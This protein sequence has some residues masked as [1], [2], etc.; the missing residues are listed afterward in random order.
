L[1]LSQ[2]LLSQNPK[3]LYNR[4]AAGWVYIEI[5]KTQCQTLAQVSHSLEMIMDLA[6]ESSEDIFWEQIR[7]QI[8][9][10]LF[11][12][13]ENTPN[14][15]WGIFLSLYEAFPKHASQANSILLKSILKHQAE[16]KT[17]ALVSTISDVANLL[18]SDFEPETLD[19]GKS[20]PS[21][22]ERLFIA[23]AKNWCIIMDANKDFQDRERIS[24]FIQRLDRFSD[25]YPQMVYLIYYRAVLR[26]KLEIYEEARILFIPFVRKKQ[27][28]FWVWEV[29]SQTFPNDIDTQIACLSK[30]LLCKTS[31][32]FLVKVRQR[33]AELL[34]LKKD[35]NSAYTEILAIVTI[36]KQNNW[37][38]STQIIDW[39]KM[40]I[41]HNAMAYTNNNILY[42]T[43]SIIAENIVSS[44]VI[45]IGVVWKIN[46]EKK[47]A[48][49]YVNENVNG[50]FN[51]EKA[52]IQ[53]AVGNLLSLS[54][55]EI[56]GLESTYFQVQS[57]EICTV[58]AS[59]NV[60]KVFTGD[61][62]I[63]GK[64]GFVENI[65]VEEKLIINTKHKVSGIAIRA[66][67]TKKLN[68]GWKAIS[69]IELE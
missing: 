59:E 36:R 17:L 47:T 64:A 48:Q 54:L 22:A 60:K 50:G 61:L 43:S 58:N 37:Q 42:K 18:L 57:A 53:V 68:W 41:A 30:A 56:K 7:W 1:A 39:Q 2:T 6:L 26:L 67:D 34:I 3:N 23:I 15:E 69:L 16:I 27:T 33:M 8:A 31:D 38:I 13:G 62:K 44:S 32:N 28:E 4:R 65:F 49:F 51:Y 46:S 9:K 12:L 52:K 40:A 63:V 5:I 14:V 24:A 20:I 11:R 45:S 10:F 66:F 25:K 35:W 55:N 19:K 21:L 29:L